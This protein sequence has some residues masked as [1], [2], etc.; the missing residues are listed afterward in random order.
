MGQQ[1]TEWIGVAPFL[2]EDLAF[3]SIAQDELGHA[4]MLYELLAEDGGVDRLAFGRPAGRLPQL[5]PRRGAVAP[6]GPMPSP[7]TGCTTSPR[8]CDGRRWPVRRSTR[9]PTSSS[10]RSARRPTTAATPTRWC[11]G[12]STTPRLVGAWRRPSTGSSRSPT[13]CGSRSPARTRPS[14]T[15]S[16][17]PDR[18]RCARR[19]GQR[20]VEVIGHVDWAALDHPD[21]QGRTQP[22]R[23]LRRPARPHQRGPRPRPDRPLVVIG[24]LECADAAPPALGRRRTLGWDR[25]GY[26]S[27]VAGSAA[28]SETA[29]SAATA[30]SASSSSA[31]C[32]S[33]PSWA[34]R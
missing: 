30:A 19:G 17:R 14:T 33:N 11:A 12:C 24:V 13:P 16:S 10:G 3:C 5:P 6:T 9:S 7:V 32:S 31:C 27:G 20:V 34:P 29:S 21:Q 28:S 8:S 26:Q 1:H 22:Q 25:R 4:A 18:R 15:A 2:E 23:A